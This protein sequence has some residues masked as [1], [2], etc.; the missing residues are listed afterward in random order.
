M[1]AK[2][3]HEEFDV[4]VVGYG[5]AGAVSAIAAHD[6]GARVIILEKLP[7]PG[8]NSI[9][10]GG[11]IIWGT[12]K[13]GTLK[14]LEA[15]SD[16]RTDDSVIDFMAQGIV[17]LPAYMDY[18]TQGSSF[19]PSSYEAPWIQ[20]PF[21]GRES[22]RGMRVIQEG[23][24]VTQFTRTADL[25][26]RKGFARQ[27][28]LLLMEMMF[29]NVK[30]RGIETMLS[31]P[32]E[33]LVQ[34][35]DGRVT[36]VIATR[37]GKQTTIKAKKAVILCC[38]GFEFNEWLKAQF[39]EIQPIYGIGC[40]GNTGDGIL[41]SQKA[42][43]ALWHM[44]LLHASYGFKFPEFRYAFR[45][46]FAGALNPAQPSIV[47]WILVNKDGARF[48]NEAIP[49]MQD[50]SYR[51]MQS[52]NTD[53]I[54]TRS[55]IPEYPN[56]PCYMILDEEGRK[57]GPIGWS[58]TALKEEKYEWS[59]DNSAELEKGWIRQGN[60][61]QELADKLGM[62]SQGL[63]KTIERWN[64]LSALNKDEDF[65][66]ITGSLAP[67]DTPPYYGIECWPIISN[68]Q[69]GPRFNIRCQ[70]VDPY[71]DAIPGLYKAG[72]LGSFF[73]HIYSLGGN[74]TE[75]IVEGRTAGENAAMESSR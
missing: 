3:W 38:G 40:T 36:G 54:S 18:L 7:I 22:I 49:Y 58:V 5:L 37:N 27:A 32:V 59:Q 11:G 8:G 64:Q 52:M 17:N 28:G 1:D 47:P 26:Q 69:G 30:K 34:N 12:D 65:N 66:R 31:C 33:R 74:L 51:G 29:H 45:V 50:A 55:G 19:N 67:I 6:S 14:Y 13:E 73:G 72:E 4:I 41:M 25:R 10:S 61:I 9:L 48:M 62:S 56:I 57:R 60:T 43:A 68:T 15:C 75:C 39:C 21:P 63:E 44:W 23:Q 2:R 42:G 70:V 20:Y 46:P 35:S 53:Y 24:D 16:A 71:G